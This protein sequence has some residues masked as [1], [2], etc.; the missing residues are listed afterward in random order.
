MPRSYVISFI[1][2]CMVLHPPTAATEQ[3]QRSAEELIRLAPTVKSGDPKFNRIEIGGYIDGQDFMHLLFRVQYRAP[4]RYALFVADG[5]D[6]T[7]II[8]F[9]NSQ[10]LMYNA[11]DSFVLYLS[12]ASFS[13]TLGFMEGKFSHR[14]LIARSDEPCGILFDVKSLYD[15]QGLG[16]AVARTG[17]GPFRLTRKLE[18]GKSFVSLV[19]PSRR[20]PFTEIALMKVDS[21][22][23]FLLIRELSVNEDARWVWPAFPRKDVL[24]GRL[25]LKDWSSDAK[26]GESAVLE[27]MARS[28]LA[29]P[30]IRYKAARQSY[31]Q[32]FG[33]R[34]DWNKVEENDRRLSRSIRELIGTPFGGEGARPGN[35]T[36]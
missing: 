9:N 26:F 32:Q 21:D 22:E 36:R 24:A 28:L 19:D 6:K 14:F 17:G 27:F 5:D 35:T 2:V 25:E 23:P 4:D 3:A 11:V 8:C 15:R 29:R 7:P 13:Y 30:A 16:D 1:A 20:C 34:N 12:N 31:E 10:L 33:V 18:G